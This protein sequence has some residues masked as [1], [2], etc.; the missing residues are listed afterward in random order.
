MIIRIRAIIKLYDKTMPKDGI[1]KID[2]CV[3]RRPIPK[4]VIEPMLQAQF[5]IP[6]LHLLLGGKLSKAIEL[7]KTMS[8]PVPTPTRKRPI[9][10][11][12]HSVSTIVK[13][14]PII[15]I[16]SPYRNSHFLPNRFEKYPNP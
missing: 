6:S 8:D 2:I 16:M 14:I 5:I 9:L 4:V 7:A 13:A 15:V 1:S 12:I 10:S 11:S 3:V